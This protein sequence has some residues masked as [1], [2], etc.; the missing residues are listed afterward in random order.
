MRRRE[1]IC[2]IGGSTAA[3]WPLAV[4]AQQPA[5]RV[6][7]ILRSTSLAFSTPMVM[8]F[9]QGLTADFGAALQEPLLL[10]AETRHHALRL[11]GRAPTAG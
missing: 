6:I 3:T 5:M 2:L 1:F 4:W 9:R 10:A 11:Q 8:G 7:G